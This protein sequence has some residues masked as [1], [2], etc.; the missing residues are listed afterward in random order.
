MTWA[1]CD[2][3]WG[4]Y[5]E[6]CQSFVDDKAH[7][8]GDRH[9]RSIGQ[10]I[11]AGGVPDRRSWGGGGHL[12]KD[13]GRPPL[14]L[15]PN[16]L[17]ELP[18]YV[19]YVDRVRVADDGWTY[20]DGDWD[21]VPRCYPPC[22]ADA[23]WQVPPGVSEDINDTRSPIENGVRKTTPISRRPRPLQ[24]TPSPACNQST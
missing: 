10:T 23:G 7:F 8:L 20:G 13:P 17:R 22:A 4:W 1:K 12:W 3:F 6:P 2:G 16:W 21:Q 9:R 24:T 19:N 18:L 5:C 15:F 11:Q 14:Y